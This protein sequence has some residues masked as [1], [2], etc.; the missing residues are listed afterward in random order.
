M[1]ERLPGAQ[2]RRFFF[3]FGEDGFENENGHI[4]QKI[5]DGKVILIGRIVPGISGETGS[6]HIGNGSFNF[7]AEIMSRINEKHITDRENTDE[8]FSSDLTS[9]QSSIEQLREDVEF[10]L[11]EKLED[12]ILDRLDALEG[13]GRRRLRR[14]RGRA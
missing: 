4:N 2:P 7:F 11:L 1:V 8:H 12:E 3:A 14:D 13:G 10:I 9:L 6:R 5:A